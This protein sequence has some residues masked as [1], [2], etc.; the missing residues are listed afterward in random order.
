[1]KVG[2]IIREVTYL[3]EL[4]KYLSNTFGCGLFICFSKFSIKQ[5]QKL[6]ENNYVI[7]MYQNRMYHIS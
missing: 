6:F 4:K 1:M 2:D 7:R 5:T 3:K